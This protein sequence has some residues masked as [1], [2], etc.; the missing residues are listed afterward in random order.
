MKKPS[1]YQLAWR[2]YLAEHKRNWKLSVP[3][4]LLPAIGSI[5]VFYIPPIIVA[6]ILD[7]FDKNA[8]PSMEQLLPYL[9][10]FGTVWL[11]GE[12]LWRI[13]IH[14]T[15]RAETRSMEQLNN[16]GMEYLFQKDIAFFHNN[17]AGAL[18]KRVV[19]YARNFEGFTDV[20]MFSVV[21][22][23]FAFLFAS[24]VLWQFSPWLVLILLG[25]TSLTFVLML[26]LIRRRQK[27]VK[28]RETANTAVSGHIADIMSNMDAVQAFSHQAFEAKAH[29]SIVRDFMYKTRRSWDYQ[30]LRIDMVAAPMFVITNLAGLW[31]AIHISRGNPESLSTIFITFSYF[32]TSTRAIWEFN[33][34]YRNIE[35]ALSEAAQFTELLLDEPAL[36]DP[37]DPEPTRIH[38]G[39]VV[40]DNVRFYYENNHQS[41]LFENLNLHIQPGE[42][43]ALVGRSGGGKTSI[44]KLLLRFMDIQEGSLRID[45]QDISRLKLEDLRRSIAYVPQEPVMFHRSLTENIRYGSLGADDTAVAQ[46]AKLAHADEF[47][48][49]LPQKYDTLVGERGVKLSGGQ[50]QRIAIARALI[51]NAPL[52]VLDE[53]TSALDSESELLIQD[54][55]WKLMEGR[56]AIVIAHRL[57]TIQKM[58]R[59]IVMDNGQ[60]IEQGS[61]KDLLKQKGTYAKLWAHQSG[62]FIED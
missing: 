54:A 40:F 46:A 60:I 52:I 28:I 48:Q 31:F 59:I 42:K 26:P 2:H 15:I 62:G 22:N 37:V 27:L 39:E 33:R 20:L 12:I 7:I 5:F 35:S 11:V 51:K 57:S 21:P 23:I 43:V 25:L 56:T 49:Q 19:G 58:D 29:R 9:L 41:P 34:I 30:N 45:G 32:A 18:T 24:V 17:F 38:A 14:L 36:T 55:L 3:G 44:T 61:H 16:Q 6:K 10:L 8:S 47:I 1:S 13:G 53:A 50:R 4:L